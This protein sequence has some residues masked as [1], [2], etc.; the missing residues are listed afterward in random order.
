VRRQAT[1]ATI[2]VEVPAGEDQVLRVEETARACGLEV[3]D[4]HAL[5]AREGRTLVTLTVRG[6]PHQHNEVRLQL[7]RATSSYRL[8]INE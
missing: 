8:S 2:S 7:L 5:P 4:L 1:E 6:K 3:S